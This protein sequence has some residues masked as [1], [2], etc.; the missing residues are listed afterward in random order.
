MSDQPNLTDV[1]DDLLMAELRNRGYVL[2]IWSKED[3]VSLVEDDEDCADLTDEQVQEAAQL[4]LDEMGSGLEE[5][6]GSR[7]NDYTLDRWESDVKDT[8]LAAIKDATPTA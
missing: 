3:V 7:G 1:S 4:A 5:V 2:S 6:L 8:V